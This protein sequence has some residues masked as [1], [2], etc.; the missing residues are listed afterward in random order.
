MS[1]NEIQLQGKMLAD[2]YRDVLISEN[3][4]NTKQAKQSTADNQGGKDAI[5]SLGKNKKNYC[6]IVSY[7][8]ETFLPD[9]KMEVLIK[10]MQACRI[11]ME[12]IALLNIAGTERTIEQIRDQFEPSK[13][14]LLGVNPTAIRLP[15]QF[16]A[17][18]P[19]SYANCTYLYADSLDTMDNSAAGRKIKSN[20]W[21][22]L[23]EMFGL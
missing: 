13:M 17:Y 23:K 16:P 21:S 22:A 18:K 9:D 2:L 14:V 1:L 8:N 3:P 10:I 19:Q 5:R 12:D 4:I 11:S 20:L 15:I 6:F 7:E